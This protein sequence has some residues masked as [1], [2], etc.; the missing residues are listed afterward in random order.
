MRA[1]TYA[2]A[3]IDAALRQNMRHAVVHAD[4][5]GGTS[6]DAAGTA[7]TDGFIQRNG[8]DKLTQ[9]FFSF[10][11]STVMMEIALRC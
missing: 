6:L 2:L 9:G 3:A 10:R 8:M 4:G 5:L 11:G 1:H 7:V